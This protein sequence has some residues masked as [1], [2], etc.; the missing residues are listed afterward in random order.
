[1]VLLLSGAAAIFG[2]HYYR[3]RF[4]RTNEDLFTLLPP[5]DGTT[6]FA[7]VA[8]LRTAGTLRLLDGA[9]ARHDADYER[10]V[11]QT[12]FNYANDLDAIA[13]KA[14]DNQLYFLLRGRFHWSQLRQYASAHGGRCADDFCT[15][16]ATEAGRNLSF[17]SIQPDV[18]AVSAGPDAEG[19]K[20]LNA[21]H[22][23]KPDSPLPEQPVWV[24]LGEDL[25]QNPVNLPL[26]LRIFAV[27]LQ[28]THP[29]V[30]SLDAAA[31]GSGS[32]FKLQ[33]DG[34]C[35]NG[36]AAETLRSQLEIQTRMLKLELAR[37]RRQPDPADLTGLL[38]AGSFQV[39]DR[40]L[41]GIWPVRNEL[42]QALQ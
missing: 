7:D 20:R 16:P 34:L 13:G 21:L 5:G 32:A 33:L 9:K 29:V 19:V 31:E 40:H 11:R 24:S 26:P 6:F 42:L 15:L 12:D 18:L 27:S 23:K 10:F 14:Q 2:I 37:E 36:A 39:A 30:L 41:I 1:M 4:V 3:H 8:L 38:T 25:L 22:H 28:S 17:S 35:R